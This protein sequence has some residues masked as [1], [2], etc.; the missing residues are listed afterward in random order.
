MKKVIITTLLFVSMLPLAA[1]AGA[2]DSRDPKKFARNI[3]NEIV[4]IIES[5]KSSDGEKQDKL[6][7]LFG[8]YVDTDWM[9]K[10]V[11]GD[12]YADLKPTK[13]KK[14]LELY[15]DYVIYTYIPRFKDYAGEKME[16]YKSEK[17]T[18]G[19]YIVK[20]YL[21]TPKSKEKIKVDYRLK[22][23]ARS[24]RVIDIVGE[25]VSLI[26]T[27]KAD[28]ATPI[29]Q[30]GVDFFVKRLDKKVQRLKDRIK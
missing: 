12:Y 13:R 23:K 7:K 14:Y 28:F 8:K 10:Y 2:I 26:T 29:S 24:F 15:K 6:F 19:E 16:F 9:G 21:I 25:G 4:R 11:L 18:G 20:S 3:A 17:K 5:E 22:K 27:Q 30:R 1:Y